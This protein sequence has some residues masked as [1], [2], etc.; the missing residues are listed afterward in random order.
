MNVIHAIKKWHRHAQAEALID[1]R[2]AEYGWPV[3][4]CKVNPDGSTV[5]YKTKARPRLAYCRG[6]YLR[7]KSDMIASTA[8][9]I[10]D[11]ELE[12]CGSFYVNGGADHFLCTRCGKR[13]IVS[14]K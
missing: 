1:K 7:A 9:R 4:K 11:H 2:C 14:Y 5:K 6:L 8:C 10:L 3:E 12:D 13:F